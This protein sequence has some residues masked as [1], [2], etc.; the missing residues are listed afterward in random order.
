MNQCYAVYQSGF[1]VYGVGITPDAAI[2][3]ALQWLDQDTDPATI[4]Q[5]STYGPTGETHGDLY[6]RPCT[7]A[8]ATAV[9]NDGG[10]CVYAL[11]DNG[12]LRLEEEFD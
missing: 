7:S 3:E 10:D 12:I 6:L 11:D 1:C 9:E 4:T 2:A 8:M 5:Y